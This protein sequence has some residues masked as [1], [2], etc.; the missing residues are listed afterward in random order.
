MDKILTVFGCAISI[1][2][3]LSEKATTFSC[4]NNK[5]VVNVLYSVPVVKLMVKFVVFHSKYTYPCIVCVNLCVCYIILST[6]HTPNCM[7]VSHYTFSV[8]TFQN[9]LYTR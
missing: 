1:S 8:I 6:P 4:L 9:E 3:T 2:E 7:M 5:F